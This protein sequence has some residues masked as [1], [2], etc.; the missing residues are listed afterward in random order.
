VFI[1]GEPCK[2]LPLIEKILKKTDTNTILI[3]NI[4][5]IPIFVEIIYNTSFFEH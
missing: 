2:I 3:I 5:K 1:I 4:K